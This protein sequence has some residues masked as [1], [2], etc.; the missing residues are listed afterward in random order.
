MEEGGMVLKLVLDIY[1]KNN[2]YN[3]TRTVNKK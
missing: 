1:V 2:I 3:W